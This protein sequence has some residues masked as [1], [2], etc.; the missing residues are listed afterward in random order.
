MKKAQHIH[1][2]LF[3]GGGEAEGEALNPALH[4]LIWWL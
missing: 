4:P 2:Q 3:W 1:P